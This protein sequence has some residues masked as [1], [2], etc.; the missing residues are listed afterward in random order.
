[1][2]C[3]SRQQNMWSVHFVC[4]PL[5][6]RSIIKWTKTTKILGE[7]IELD[8]SVCIH[9]E[10]ILAAV[11]YMEISLICQGATRDDCSLRDNVSTA[12]TS[13]TNEPSH[14][15]EQSWWTRNGGQVQLWIQIRKQVTVMRQVWLQS[16]S[17]RHGGLQIIMINSLGGDRHCWSRSEF[18]GWAETGL[19]IPSAEE[20]TGC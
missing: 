18:P 2:C 9:S 16:I 15:T 17:D 5:L 10:V 19:L 7:N 1:M 13:P 20:W 3:R 4:F 8:F 11:K 12:R 14:C 6:Q